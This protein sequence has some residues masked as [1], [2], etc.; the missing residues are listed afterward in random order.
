MWKTVEEIKNGTWADVFTQLEK[1]REK[2]LISKVM[3]KKGT[4]VFKKNEMVF[5]LGNVRAILTLDG[6]TFQFPENNELRH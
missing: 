2:L 6:F 5:F 1:D 3:G 4:I